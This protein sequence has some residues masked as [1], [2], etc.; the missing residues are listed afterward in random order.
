MKGTGP[1]RIKNLTL[2][3]NPCRLSYHGK[4]I[5]ISRYNFFEQLKKNHLAQHL[6][7]K[8]QEQAKAGMDMDDD[9][10]AVKK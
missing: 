9:G 8:I 2:A 10:W 5:I 7:E 6:E 4:E 1:D 3:S